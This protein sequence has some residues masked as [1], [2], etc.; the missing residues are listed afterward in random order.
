P[1]PDGRMAIELTEDERSLVLTEMRDFLI[2]VQTITEAIT[3]EDMEMATK[4]AR[5]V[6]SAAQGAVP[7]SLVSK[8][9]NEFKKLGFDTHQQFDQIGLDAEQLG[10]GSHTLKQLGHLMKNCI[11]CHAGYKLVAVPEK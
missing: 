2:S 5:K 3:N 4:A 7:L 11:S 1:S 9:P 10:D 6:G 8:L